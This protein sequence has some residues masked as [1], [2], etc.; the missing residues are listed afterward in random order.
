MKK[1]KGD[2]MLHNALDSIVPIV[3]ALETTKVNHEVLNPGSV[4]S[5]RIRFAT[6]PDLMKFTV[7]WIKNGALY[8]D[9]KREENLFEIFFMN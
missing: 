1:M 5:I 9:T 3:S 7:Q 2:I 6:I 8:R 4:E